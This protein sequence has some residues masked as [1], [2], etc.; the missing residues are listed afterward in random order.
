M[1]LRK[2]FIIIGIMCIVVIA[3]TLGGFALV[4]A[5]ND[6]ANTT[7]TSTALTTLM[8][9][10]ASIYQQNTGTAIDPAQLQK[11]FEAAGTAIRAD[12]LDQYLQKLVTDGKI[13]QTQADAWKAWWNSRP[14]TALS[15]EMKTWMQAQPDI[16]GLSGIMGGRGGCFGSGNGQT[17]VGPM[18]RDFGNSNTA[19]GSMMRG[20]ARGSTY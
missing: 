5:A 4:G 16:P 17:K 13:T 15:D 3:G 9:K 8:D 14:T 6:S 20:F 12:K 19:A 10:V 7:Q 2:K 11:A 1:K 18:M